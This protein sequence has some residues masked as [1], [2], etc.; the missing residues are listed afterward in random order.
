VLVWR[1]LLTLIDPNRYLAA[2]SEHFHL[3]Q[4]KITEYLKPLN[5]E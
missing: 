4:Q 1:V 2:T 3:H 5:S